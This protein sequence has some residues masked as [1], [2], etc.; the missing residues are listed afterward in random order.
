MTTYWV[1]TAHVTDPTVCCGARGEGDA[2][3]ARH[4]ERAPKHSTLTTTRRAL[5]DELAGPTPEENT[6]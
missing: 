1:C 4:T 2:G 5:A 6:T 3:A